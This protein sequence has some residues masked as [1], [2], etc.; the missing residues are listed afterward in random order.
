VSKVLRMRSSLRRTV[1]AGIVAALAVTTVVPSYADHDNGNGK[2]QDHKHADKGKKNPKPPKPV[3]PCTGD[4]SAVQRMSLPVAGQDALALVSLPRK[5]P[6][7]IV[8]F[9][10]GYGHTMESWREHITRTAAN[11][12]VIAIAPNYRGQE[13]PP[14]GTRISSRGWRVAEGAADTIA[15]AQHFERLCTPTG[16]NVVYG[17]SMGGNTSGLVVAAK[18]MGPDGKPLFDYWVDVE[19]AVNVTQ[20]Y[21]GASAL[22]PGNAFAKNAAED[23]E[24]AFGGSIAQVPEVYAERTVVNRTGDIAASGIRGVVLVHGVADGLVTYNQSRELQSL[25]RVRGVPVDMWSAVTRTEDSEPGTT[26]DG[27]LPTGQ[28][29]PFAG[30][31]S[32]TSTT[33]VVGMAGFAA[34]DRLYSGADFVCGEAVFDGMLERTASTSTGC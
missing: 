24:A 33:H 25:L 28:T 32:E 22:A 13:I 6:R 17:V 5:K 19:G 23:I 4:P 1:L 15:Y 7:G 3:D 30:H 11:L 27:Y 9:D 26:I 31:A 8:V 16:I 34:L 10:H 12:G 20:T 21:L 14:P 18:P 2:S 29:S